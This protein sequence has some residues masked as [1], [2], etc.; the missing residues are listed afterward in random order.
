MTVR[1]LQPHTSPQ[2][3]SDGQSGYGP[4]RT[5]QLTRA[6]RRNTELLDRG[7]PSGSTE[8]PHE[9]MVTTVEDHQDNDCAGYTSV[10]H[11]WKIDWN[12]RTVLKIHG[13]RRARF[14]PH[15]EGMPYPDELVD[16]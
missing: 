9:I 12:S 13:L 8:T 6:L 11:G 7:R 4:V 14:T 3:Q 15:R 5:T 2:H 10:G 1:K 16:R